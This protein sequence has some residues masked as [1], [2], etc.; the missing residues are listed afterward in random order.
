MFENALLLSRRPRSVSLDRLYLFQINLA[1]AEVK[2]A[3]LKL[4]LAKNKL[5]LT[6]Y[7]INLA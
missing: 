6:K 7:K 1:Q 5:N 4:N 2:M 3:K